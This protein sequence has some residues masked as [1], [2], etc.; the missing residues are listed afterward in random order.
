[1]AAPK[2]PTLRSSLPW[3]PRADSAALRQAGKTI[4]ENLA[5]CP[6]LVEGQKIVSTFDKPVKPTGHI[7]ILQVSAWVSKLVG[8]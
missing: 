4:A 8:R 1:M 6:P 3:P 7:A 5:D 2:S